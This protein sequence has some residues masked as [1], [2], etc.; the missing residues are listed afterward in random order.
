MEKNLKIAMFAWESLHSVKVG[1][2]APHVSELS[3]SLASLGHSVHIFTRNNGLA[4]YDKINGVHYHRVDHDL[5]GGIVRQMDSMCDAMYARFLDVSVGSEPFD[6]LHVHDWHPVNVVSRLKYELGTPFIITYHSTEWGRNGN[7]HGNWW[8]AGEISHR[9]WKGGYESSKVIVTSNHFKDEIQYLYQIP[10]WKISIVSN[11]IFRGKM[12]KDV[13]AGEIKKRFGIHPFA[14]VVLFVG[15]MSY[16]KGPD[17]LVGAVPCVLGHRWDVRFVFIGEGEMRP[18]CE[19]L[20]NKACVADR[21][22]FLGYADDSTVRDWMNACDILCVPSRNEPFGIVV[23]EGWDAEKNIVATDAVTIIENFRDGV[24]TYRNPGSVAWGI[25]YVLDNVN[26]DRYR[27]AGRELIKNKFN[28]YRIAENTIALYEKTL[29]RTRKP[30]Y[31][32]PYVAGHGGLL[33]HN[34]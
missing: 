29:N 28:W 21:C 8:E 5:S 11:G 16:Q 18:H 13:D 34:M 7:V 31:C 12:K 33:R 3:E 15:R 17:M 23:L 27:R 30:V 4:S 24:L 9:E 14:P 25:N 10:D 19:Y 20:A 1:G 6:V 26:D 2:L 32:L 22:H